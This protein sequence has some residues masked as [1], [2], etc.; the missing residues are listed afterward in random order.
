MRFPSRARIRRLDPESAI[1]LACRNG[2]RAIVYR[3]EE[4]NLLDS[5]DLFQALTE[6]LDSPL[7]RVLDL[8]EGIETEITRTQS[9]IEHEALGALRS[10]MIGITG[11]FD[12]N[13]DL[14][15]ESTYETGVHL[16]NAGKHSAGHQ[17]VKGTTDNL[18]RD[19]VRLELGYA[20]G[21]FQDGKVSHEGLW[22][23]WM[24]G[25]FASL[26]VQGA[27]STGQTGIPRTDASR[28]APQPS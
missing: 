9:V 28:P 4:S 22:K 18:L 21:L 3:G 15:L 27:D 8:L 24:P 20:Q 5:E 14:W 16:L 19:L 2:L 13:T 1:A 26:E 7:N 23:N 6:P 10:S 12:R 25:S 11:L 17:G